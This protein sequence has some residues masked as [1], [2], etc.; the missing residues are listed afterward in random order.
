MRKKQSVVS[1]SSAEAEVKSLD[2]GFRIGVS[3]LNNYGNLPARETTNISRE[4]QRS[5]IDDRKQ[6]ELY[7]VPEDIPNS[8][9]SAVLYVC[10]DTE[11]VINVIVRSRRPSVRHVTHTPCVDLDW[12]ISIKYND[13]DQIAD[14]LKIKTNSSATV[15]NTHACVPHTHKFAVD[16]R[17]LPRWLR[18]QIP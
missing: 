18:C 14:I 10:E 2:A 3:P 5:Q 4:E 16:V 17:N 11:A 6:R 15:D 12:L 1:Q 9:Y 7:Y 13:T 8:A